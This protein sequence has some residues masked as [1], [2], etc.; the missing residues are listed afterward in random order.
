VSDEE[1]ILPVIV[2]ALSFSED[3]ANIVVSL[4]TKYS[5]IELKYSVPVECFRDLLIDVQRLEASKANKP[6]KAKGTEP[7]PEVPKAVE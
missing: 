4:K 6:G 7:L 2:V 5:G 3:G 1:K